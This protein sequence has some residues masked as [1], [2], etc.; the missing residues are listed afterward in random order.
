MPIID[1]FGII[2]PFYDRVIPVRYAEKIIQ[3]SGLPVAGAV[4]DAGGGTGRVAE[5]VKPLAAQTVV[6]DLSIKMLRQAQMKEG[7]G[8]ACSHTECLP[9]VEGYFERVIMIDALHHVCDHAE[10]ARELWRVLK[11]GGWIVIVEPDINQF[12]V[13]LVALGEKVALMRSHFISPKKIAAL[14]NYPEADVKIVKDGFNAWVIVEKAL[15][16]P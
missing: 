14:F 1:H 2:A 9:F 5:V 11:P 7:L 8:L 10:T 3:M 15:Q 13:K 16:H 6:S 4:L 12:S